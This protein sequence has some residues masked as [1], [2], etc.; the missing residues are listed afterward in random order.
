MNIINKGDFAI[1]NVNNCTAMSFRTPSVARIN[2]ENDYKKAVK[3]EEDLKSKRR[4]D[5]KRS[6]KSRKRRKTKP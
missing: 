1:T 3:E 5:T 4:K 6:Q 2:F